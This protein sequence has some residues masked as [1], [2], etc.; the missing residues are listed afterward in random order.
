M[1]QPPE[2][3]KIPESV[4]VVEQ[5]ESTRTQLVRTLHEL[6]C[7][8]IV[9]CGD[10]AQ[11]WQ[12]LKQS[13]FELVVMQWELPGLSGLALFNR[14][15]CVPETA[16]VPIVVQSK[17]MHPLDFELFGEFPL[18]R[19][20]GAPVAVRQ[21]EPVLIELLTE[22]TWY[23]GR[24]NAIEGVLD[25]L[26]RDPK[27]AVD[28]LQRIL[29]TSP[30]PIPLALIIADGLCARGAFALA[31]KL[32]W[33]IHQ[34]RPRNASVLWALARALH[35]AGRSAEARPLLAA[36]GRISPRN[37]ERL[38][39]AGQVELTLG[40][41]ER[42]RAAFERC[43]AVDPGYRPAKA[44]C[45]IS[46]ALAEYLSRHST[47]HLPRHLAATCN[48]I[49]VDLA[50]S[51][52]AKEAIEHYKAALVLIEKDPEVFRVVFNLGLAHLRV[53]QCEAAEKQFVKALRLS[54]GRFTK[55][56]R[57][58]EL[59]R[60]MRN[61]TALNKE[62]DLAEERLIEKAQQRPADLE[63]ELD[64]AIADLPGEE[65]ADSLELRVI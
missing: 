28:A 1:M 4:L 6:G 21:L 26:A 2:V 27:V 37:V 19:F 5:D 65:L 54:Q 17:L 36:A 38:C 23:A 10:G 47:T 60:E 42:A 64:L 16:F 61:D 8:G 34:A 59:A 18:V 40:D 32:L 30:Q 56:K 35:L 62:M 33:P 9:A 31:E 57:Y 39:F 24:A 20:L 46:D 49:G 55:A 15:R 14:L 58:L 52:K 53:A 12:S 25:E 7:S 41:A 48:L 11:A 63:A 29:D 51:D 44:G 45:K 13:G 22:S 3:L 43:L 50:Q